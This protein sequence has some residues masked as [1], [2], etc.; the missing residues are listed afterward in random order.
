MS[1]WIIIGNFQDMSPSETFSRF[2]TRSISCQRIN[3][4]K[5]LEVT[6]I[7]YI[8]SNDIF[9][10]RVKAKDK[11]AFD[12]LAHLLAASHLPV[13]FN[14]MNSPQ[15]FGFSATN[16]EAIGLFLRVCCE[17]DEK[18]KEIEVLFAYLLKLSSFDLTYRLPLWHP[19]GN[20]QEVPIPGVY[21]GK[22][23]NYKLTAATRVISEICLS[24]R[25]RSSITMSIGF[26]TSE[27]YQTLEKQLMAASLPVKPG[28]T[29]LWLD[30]STSDIQAF[31]L[32]LRVLSQREPAIQELFSPIARLLGI[33]AFNEDYHLPRW[34][35][36]GDFRECYEVGTALTREII[37][38]ATQPNAIIFDIILCGYTE[39]RFRVFVY[40]KNHAYVNRIETSL[41]SSN[42]E[43]QKVENLFMQ[44]S[45]KFP[46]S[47]KTEIINF[48][49]AIASVDSSVREVMALISSPSI[50]NLPAHS[51]LPVEHLTLSGG[52]Q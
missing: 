43:Y 40:T 41:R 28:N 14:E 12:R 5:V 24:Q 23:I 2:S 3:E 20:F 45:I 39:N 42:Q 19:I 7:T 25:Q 32:F 37:Y 38:H 34:L 22:Q 51:A 29:V 15:M 26:E 47:Q 10:I 35:P 27:D 31:G 1:D 50:L 44:Y 52:P 33:A 46:T 6:L 11:A 16:K 21:V 8:P 49:N 18:V 9:T 36:E 48:L 13:D 4:G 30:F 17:E